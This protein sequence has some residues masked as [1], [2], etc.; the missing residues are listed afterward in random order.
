MFHMMIGAASN[1]V[2]ETLVAGLTNEVGCQAAQGLARQFVEAEGADFHWEA[3][4]AQRWLGAWENP[5]DAD[6]LLDRMAVTGRLGDSFYV[7]ILIV[8]SWD[9][10]Q[11]MLGLR[12]FRTEAEALEAY[13]AAR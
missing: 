6:E 8:D 2:F 11:A 7:A 10:V 3:R 4:S 12:Q 13:A 5:D 9:D 1:H